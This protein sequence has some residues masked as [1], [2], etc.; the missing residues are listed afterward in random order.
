MFAFKKW[1]ALFSNI[2]ISPLINAITVWQIAIVVHKA[3]SATNATLHFSLTLKQFNVNRNAL[4]NSFL[5]VNL[6][7][8][9]IAKI[10]LPILFYS[11]VISV[12]QI[13]HVWRATLLNTKFNKMGLV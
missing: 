5:I 3:T 9:I 6:I 2:M 10:M 7:H 4:I 1:N 8:V 12:F 11:S 13:Q